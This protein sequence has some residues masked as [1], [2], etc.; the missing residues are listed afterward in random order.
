MKKKK[1]KKKTVLEETHWRCRYIQV[2]AILSGKWLLTTHSRRMDSN[3]SHWA[4]LQKGDKRARQIQ[5]IVN[6]MDSKAN[7]WFYFDIHHSTWLFLN[8]QLRNTRNQ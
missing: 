4:T 3:I 5:F 1:K 7:V 8:G 2:D 6:N